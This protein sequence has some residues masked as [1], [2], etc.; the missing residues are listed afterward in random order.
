MRRQSVWIEWCFWVKGRDLFGGRRGLVRGWSRGARRQRNGHVAGH[1][2]EMEC[3]KATP[4]LS[5]YGD[6]LMVREMLQDRVPGT[7]GETEEMLSRCP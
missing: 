1:G 5:V 3:G 7:K 4:P 2:E 6:G